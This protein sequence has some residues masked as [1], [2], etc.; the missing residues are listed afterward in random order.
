MK[1]SAQGFQPNL[2]LDK[3]GGSMT[4]NPME[5]NKFNKTRSQQNYLSLNHIL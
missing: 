3:I 5:T 4:V 2:N 1:K